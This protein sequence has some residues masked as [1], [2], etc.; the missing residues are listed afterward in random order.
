MGS[1]KKNS[2]SSAYSRDG[3]VG[4]ADERSRPRSGPGASA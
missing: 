3:S 1:F 2:A 4:E